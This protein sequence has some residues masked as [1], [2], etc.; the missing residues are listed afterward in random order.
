M[1]AP[2]VPHL[3]RS[4][5]TGTRADHKRAL[6]DDDMKKVFARLLQSDAI[7]PA[8]KG[9]QELFIL[10]FLLRGLPF[11]DL[12][13]LRK[14]DLRGDVITYRR[15]KTGRPLSVTLTPEAMF[16]LQKYMNRDK[17]SSYLFAIHRIGDF[18]REVFG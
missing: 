7:T 15:R 2:Y 11:V 8:M 9:A 3:F 12:A 14:S 10:M 16:L 6:C 17:R 13:Y 18:Y 1:K 5:Y 4:V